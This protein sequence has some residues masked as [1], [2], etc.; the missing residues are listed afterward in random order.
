[1]AP[2]AL[3][4]AVVVNEPPRRGDVGDVTAAADRPTGDERSE[5]S[6]AG[7]SWT[8]CGGCNVATG[9][10]SYH[11]GYRA[12]QSFTLRFRGVQVLVYA[13]DDRFG[14]VAGVTV[15]GRPAAMPTV[16]FLTTG[17]PANRHV[18]DSGLLPDGEH[19]VVFTIL[20]G[21]TD[22]VAL[23]DRADVFTP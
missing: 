18:W 22:N 12:G 16:D 14:G 20:P 6:Y 23:F 1:M 13:P 9:D 19:T 17:T 8:R 5:A 2:G 7:D 21:R 3:A 4:A 15:D 10:R 11:Y